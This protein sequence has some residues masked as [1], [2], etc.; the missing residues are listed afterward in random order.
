MYPRRTRRPIAAACILALIAAPP[1]WV[2]RQ[3][4]QHSLNRAIIAAIE[5]SDTIKVASLL[6]SGAD[7]N[8]RVTLPEHASL[9]SEIKRLL[10]LGHRNSTQQPLWSPSVR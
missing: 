1:V 3:F 8:T 5:Q 4:H 2:A 9:I 6:A 10:H 7:P